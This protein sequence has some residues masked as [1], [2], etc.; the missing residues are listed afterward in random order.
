MLGLRGDFG[1]WIGSD[2]VSVGGRL[3][4]EA[5]LH[6][7]EATFFSGGSHLIAVSL[8]KR[9]DLILVAVSWFRHQI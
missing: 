5:L 1:L 2:P 9:L 8:R 6:R 4:K 3:L 7:E